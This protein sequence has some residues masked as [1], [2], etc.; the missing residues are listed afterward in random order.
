MKRYRVRSEMGLVA[1]AIVLSLPLSACDSRSPISATTV[2]SD[3]S[4]AAMTL[5]GQVFEVTPGGRVPAADV[6]VLA[7]VATTSGCAAPCTSMT[8]VSRERTTSGPDGRY[9]FPRLNAGS[10]LVLASKDG[11]QQVCGAAVTLGAAT[12]L[13]VEITSRAN[14]QPSPTMPPLKV[15]GQVYETTPTGRVGLDGASI[16]IDWPAPDSPFLTVFAGKDGR[17]SICGIP[18]NT[19]IA[20]WTGRIGYTD[21]YI[22]HQFSADSTI[23][24]ELTRH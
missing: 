24:I 9:N 7:V 10:A 23:D 20:L 1:A 3:V 15:T 5:S 17:Y 16:G 4:A 13:D 19:P 11:Y 6:S 22:W 21:T 12:Q 18:A 14:P 8:T 2:P